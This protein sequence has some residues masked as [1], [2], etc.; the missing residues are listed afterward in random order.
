MFVING[1][2]R[3]SDPLDAG[4]IARV[5]GL[6]QRIGDTFFD[7][8]DDGMIQYRVLV[9]GRDD[10]REQT[11]LIQSDRDRESRI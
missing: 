2:T 10:T 4:K 11:A 8:G 5:R 6:L 1:R 7:S 9:R 3:V